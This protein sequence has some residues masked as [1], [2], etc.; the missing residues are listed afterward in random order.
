MGGGWA[1]GANKPPPPD[2][3]T[4]PYVVLQL[5]SDFTSVEL[6]RSYRRES[7]RNHPDK[8]GGEAGFQ[9]V[10]EAHTMLSDET[11]RRRFDEGDE[12]PRLAAPYTLREEIQKFYFPELLGFRP[13][14]DPFEAW[15]HYARRSAQ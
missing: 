3:A 2:A 1:W 8:G 15:E 5:P 11:L 9:A 4:D 12:L 6:K 10:A 7:K 13:F 14:G